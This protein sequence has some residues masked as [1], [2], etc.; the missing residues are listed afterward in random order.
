MASGPVLESPG[1]SVVKL[2]GFKDRS[3][4]EFLSNCRQK[5]TA[6]QRSTTPN[7]TTDTNCSA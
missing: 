5:R 1:H 4:T 7:H 6:A 2:A 3:L